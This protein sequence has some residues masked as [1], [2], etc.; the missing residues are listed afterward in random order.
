M[1]FTQTGGCLPALAVSNGHVARAYAT[2]FDEPLQMGC[3]AS[4]FKTKLQ[5]FGWPLTPTQD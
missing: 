4:S 3:R 5:A 1:K 2:P